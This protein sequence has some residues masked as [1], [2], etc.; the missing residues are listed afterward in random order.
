MY[1]FFLFIFIHIYIYIYI[2]FVSRPV[3]L[4]RPDQQSETMSRQ[5]TTTKEKA[6]KK[7]ELRNVGATSEKATR[8][9]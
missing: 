9:Q 5:E 8:K 2:T 6:N 7:Q 4:A 1:F 3:D